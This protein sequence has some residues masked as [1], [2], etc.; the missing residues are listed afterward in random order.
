MHVQL[1]SESRPDASAVHFDEVQVVAEAAALADVGAAGE[2][3]EDAEEADSTDTLRAHPN[4][5]GGGGGGG[6][7]QAAARKLQLQAGP[8]LLALPLLLRTSAAHS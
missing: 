4:V 1:T 6:G 2:V 7:T 5:S 8:G 3:S